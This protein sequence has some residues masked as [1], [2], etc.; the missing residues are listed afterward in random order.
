MKKYFAFLLTIALFAANA[1]IVMANDYEYTND[2]YEY[3]NEY[4][5]P[6]YDYVDEEDYKEEYEVIIFPELD[7]G[8]WISG[9]DREFDTLIEELI[10]HRFGEGSEFLLPYVIDIN[11]T[12]TAGRFEIEVI[13][14]IAFEGR[15]FRA[16]FWD[17]HT[18]HVTSTFEV[19]EETG[20][21]T[22]LST[23][24]FVLDEETGEYILQSSD[25]GIPEV[26]YLTEVEAHIFIAVRDLMGELDM[27]RDAHLE[28][29][30]E[31]DEFGW[32]MN[33]GW[34]RFIHVARETDRAYFSI[35][36]RDEL[37]EVPNQLD[38]SFAIKYFLTD[39]A[40]ESDSAGIDFVA[41]LAG[42][43]ASFI[44]VDE[45]VYINGDEPI[46]NHRW[47]STTHFL[48]ELMGVDF[49]P[50]SPDFE[51]MAI[52]E[53]NIRLADGNYLTNIAITDDVVL[54]I[55]RHVSQHIAVRTGMAWTSV[56]L[57]DVRVEAMQNAMWDEMSE[58]WS[59]WIEAGYDW[60]DF[61]DSWQVEILAE[62]DALQVRDLYNINLTQW[63][64]RDAPSVTEV[65]YF[66]RDM[67]VLSYLD[68]MIHSSFYETQA[69]LPFSFSGIVPVTRFAE[70]EFP[71]IYRVFVQDRYLNLTDLSVSMMEIRFEVHDTAFFLD[72][73]RE[74]FISPFDLFE[75]EFIMADGEI[76]QGL[77][78]GGAMWAWP[79]EGDELSA[80]QFAFDFFVDVREVVGVIINGTEIRV[81]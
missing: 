78:F 42:H 30:F 5:W 36:I 53:L 44:I 20:E 57:V 19:D 76:L 8:W 3:D 4:A 74:Q 69:P 64:D 58:R 65:G 63:W 21:T 10:F 2:E 12:F 27:S 15:R 16:P 45:Y 81:R 50:M 77:W 70:I 71:G 62:I 80:S 52:G 24:I 54:R 1:M 59:A 60:E 38:I 40:W 75:I 55:Q 39:F 14:A 49:D 29:Q 73:D 33:G 51:V 26:I 35:Q 79:Y 68:F 56:D 47:G 37:K 46:P 48:E 25:E 32:P 11:Q 67:D 7:F 23:E 18:G 17:F 66:I 22:L 28:L 72:L 34:P 13:G 41:L 31:L 9:W 61:D 43:E 6:D